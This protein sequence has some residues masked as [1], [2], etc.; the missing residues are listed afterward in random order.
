MK[1]S[2]VEWK[3]WGEVDPL[4]GVA[5]A[6]GRARGGPDP[7]TDEEFYERGRL[8]WERFLGE[9]RRYGL[10]VAQCLE[11][12]CGAGRITAHLAQTFTTVHAVD[13]SAAM[14][15]Y[16]GARVTSANVLFHVTDGMTLPVENASVSAVFSTHVFQHFDSVAQATRYFVEVARVLAPGGTLMIHLPVHRWATLPRVFE[17][18]YRARKR[19]G[20]IRARLL[21]PLI[22]R[23]WV[24]PLM[25]YLSYPVEYVFG[26]LPPLGLV[27]VEVV[28]L[29]AQ[30]TSDLHPF[31]LARREANRSHV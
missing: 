15:A 3:R 25:R 8:H 30:A 20:D 14:I 1:G 28:I 12:G 23:G 6:V 10:D 5:T 9:W 22:A 27:D 24:R 4:Y 13:V 7:W 11:I 31:V 26:T 2:N 18:A 29:A 19:A 16:A 21:R 17:L